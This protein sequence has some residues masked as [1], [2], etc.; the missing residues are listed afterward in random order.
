MCL[1]VLA[2]CPDNTRA[3]AEIRRRGLSFVTPW[4]ARVLHRT[5][6]VRGVNVG[7]LKK[8]WDVLRTL[9]FIEQRVSKMTPIL[10][11]GAYGSEV[12]YSLNKMGFANL[13][14]IDL[15]P[16]LTRMP[17]EQN[18]KHVTGDFTRTEFPSETFG[19]ITVIS[20]LEHGFCG[21]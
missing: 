5:G 11:L 8:S 16:A 14:G 2:N 1:E 15:N 10:D 7:L 6:I 21:P 20:V 12:L 19:A 9:Q 13:T 18:I 17:N 3:R 4:F